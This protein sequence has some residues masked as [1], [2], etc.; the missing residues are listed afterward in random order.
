MRTMSG[1]DMVVVEVGVAIAIEKIYSGQ[2]RF[3]EKL[4]KTSDQLHQCD[5]QRLCTV[6]DIMYFARAGPHFHVAAP[7]N[8]KPRFFPE[9]R[10][11]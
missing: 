6:A 4:K 8:K 2:Q 10:G 3:S 7:E 9:N 5:T 11:T 1:G